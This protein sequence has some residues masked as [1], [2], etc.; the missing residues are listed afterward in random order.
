MHSAGVELEPFDVVKAIDDVATKFGGRVS[1]RPMASSSLSLAAIKPPRETRNFA[2]FLRRW[3]GYCLS[4]DISEE[5]LVFLYGPGGN[6]KGVFVRTITAIMGTYAVTLPMEAFTIGARLPVEYYRAQIAGARLVTASETEG[7][8]TWAEGQVK[9]LTGNEAP[10][11][12]GIRT[13]GRSH[14]FLNASCNW[15]GIMR[16]G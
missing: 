11:S 10:I 3:T 15:S 4:G 1:P 13:V 5:A 12:A 16:R 8:K 9:E 7:G 2:P 14:I 6:G